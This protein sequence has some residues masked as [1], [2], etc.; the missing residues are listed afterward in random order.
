MREQFDKNRKNKVEA[1]EDYLGDLDKRIGEVVSDIHINV[2]YHSN[3]TETKES[4]SRLTR[5][6][7]RGSG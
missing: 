1:L 6:N 4:Y 2:D 7:I 3:T 5:N